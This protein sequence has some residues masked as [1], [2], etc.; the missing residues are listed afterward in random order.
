MGDQMNGQPPGYTT[1]PNAT[2]PN[3][4]LVL[5][6][7]QPAAPVI[8]APG[9]LSGTDLN[10]LQTLIN[11]FGTNSGNPAAP[12]NGGGPATNPQVSGGRQAGGVVA[13]TTNTGAQLDQ[14][15]ASAAGTQAGQGGLAGLLGGGGSGGSSGLA[16]ALAS[17]F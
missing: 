16:G 17:L 7:S 3:A 11:S 5:G 8:N 13:G 12:A 2:D 1:D 14:T 4:T 6:G 9:Q 10:S 15:M